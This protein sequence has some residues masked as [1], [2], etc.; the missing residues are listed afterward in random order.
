MRLKHF[1]MKHFSF[2]HFQMLGGGGGGLFP[3]VFGFR[4]KTGIRMRFGIH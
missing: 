1:S 2:K 4:S 3:Q